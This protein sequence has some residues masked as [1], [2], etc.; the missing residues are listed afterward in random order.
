MFSDAA[1]RPTEE[2]RLH[3]AQGMNDTGFAFRE[4]RSRK[5]SGLR[6]K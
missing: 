2:S 1:D 5:V 6:K 4:G 3:T